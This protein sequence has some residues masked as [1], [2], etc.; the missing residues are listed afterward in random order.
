MFPVFFLVPMP[1]I[2]LSDYGKLSNSNKAFTKNNRDCFI[3]YYCTTTMLPTTFKC[4]VKS[5]ID[6]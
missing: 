5:D 6:L 4:Q 1:Y 3:R 2:Y